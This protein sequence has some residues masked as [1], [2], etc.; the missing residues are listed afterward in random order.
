VQQSLQEARRELLARAYFDH[1]ATGATPPDSAAVAAFYEQRPELFAQRRHFAI[2]EIDIEASDGQLE[3]LKK[4]LGEMPMPAFV[5]YLRSSGL[6]YK[7][8]LVNEPSENL[9]MDLIGQLV[10]MKAGHSV[11]VTRPGGLKV[12]LLVSAQPSP[13]TLSEATPAIKR[14]LLNEQGRKAIEADIEAMRSASKVEYFGRFVSVMA[15]PAAAS[16]VG[17]SL[18]AAAGNEPRKAVDGR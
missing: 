14:Y 11:Y 15:A 12:I 16:G 8:R 7:S 3:A 1:L 2:Q 4:Q 6:R 17:G 13:V 5:E 9:S 18:P 10:S